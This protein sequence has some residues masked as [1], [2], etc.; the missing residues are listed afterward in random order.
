M[1]MNPQADSPGP[2]SG[3]V[4]LLRRVVQAARGFLV[5][6][7]YLWVILGLFA[8]QQ[9]ILLP[10]EGYLYGQ[11]IAILN[12]L[13]LG[14][15]VY[16]GEHVRIGENFDTRPLIYPVLFKSGLFALVLIGFRFIESIARGALRGESLADSLS[17]IG[18]GTLAGILSI[19]VIIFVTL[20]P[21]F[22]FREMVKLVGVDVMRELLFTRRRRL[23]PVIEQDD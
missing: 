19:G 21:F 13:V 23:A 15:V 10:E 18:G 12:A 14:K 11:G 2:E 22:S 17:E 9:S 5:I 7:A 6:S 16:F 1:K 4:S 20:I 8:L 3:G